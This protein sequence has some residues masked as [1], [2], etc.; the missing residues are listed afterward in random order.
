VSADFGIFTPLGSTQTFSFPHRAP[1]TSAQSESVSHRIQLVPVDFS[2]ALDAQPKV[3]TTVHSPK[4]HFFDV[5][6]I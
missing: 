2:V 4:P 1:C 6:S 3:A 5:S